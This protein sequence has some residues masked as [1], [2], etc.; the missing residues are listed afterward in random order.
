MWQS[1]N[2]KIY[3]ITEFTHGVLFVE[4]D[5]NLCYSKRENIVDENTLR[6]PFSGG[7]PGWA[8]D[9]RAEGPGPL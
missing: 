3:V 5:E 8:E 9:P 1:F 6:E 4:Y 7:S 2:Q